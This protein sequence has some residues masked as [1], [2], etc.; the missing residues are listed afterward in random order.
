MIR[1]F[2]AT[3]LPSTISWIS[4]IILLRGSVYF[5]NL[6]AP[7]IQGGIAYSWIQPF[8]SN[9]IAAICC[10]I[11]LVNIQVF[12]L[13][14]FFNR[15]KFTRLNTSIVA[16]FYVLLSAIIPEFQYC[17]PILISATFIIPA[18][19]ILFSTYRNFS[20]AEKLWNAGLLIGIAG[21]FHPPSILLL[22]AAIAALVSFRAFNLQELLITFTGGLLPYFLA[23]VGHFWFEKLSVLINA[24]F[25][26]DQDW[27][28]FEYWTQ[29]S[30]LIQAGVL[31]VI[32]VLVVLRTPKL[33]SHTN[34]RT[35]V[36]LGATYLILG[37]IVASSMWANGWHLQHFFL[38]CFP[39]AVFLTQDVLGQ[40]NRG[41]GNLLII[42][43]F[44]VLIFTHT[45]H[46]FTL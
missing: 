25:R 21:L 5:L 38:L 37:F 7:S 23:F 43:M 17:P 45:Q 28:D 18:F 36:N 27:F 11:V 39:I 14:Q 2:R 34:A 31:I 30:T 33:Y 8:I 32:L 1:L 4:L 16:L 42:L 19:D 26:S 24:Q 20:P 41:W 15:N 10:G 3:D 44:L 40:K 13:I 6:T 12:F 9:Q 29:T 22:G 46:I 35:R